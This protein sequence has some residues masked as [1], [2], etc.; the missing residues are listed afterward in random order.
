MKHGQKTAVV[1]SKA[2]RGS[3][4]YV[5]EVVMMCWRPGGGSGS[6]CAH[7]KSIRFG[8]ARWQQHTTPTLNPKLKPLN[9]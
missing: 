1:E 9:P 7:S 2:D 8:M 6:S 4:V 5:V 3:V